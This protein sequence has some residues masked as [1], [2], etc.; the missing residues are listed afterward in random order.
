MSG[1]IDLYNKSTKQ[2]V[3]DARQIPGQE[4]DMWDQEQEF[5][6][7]F[8]G[9]KTPHSPTDFTP[10]ALEE[11][12]VMWCRRLFIDGA[13]GR[14]TDYTGSSKNEPESDRVDGI[15]ARV[16]SMDGAKIFSS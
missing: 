6:A 9:S 15:P 7:G 8:K 14:R 1:L 3:A 13:T 16:A 2:R 11:Y 12:D 4:T 10:R 5:A